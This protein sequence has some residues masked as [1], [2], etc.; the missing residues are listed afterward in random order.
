MN[1]YTH[2]AHV[3][4]EMYCH[5]FDYRKEFDFYHSILSEFS[6]VSI[7]EHGCGSGHLAKHFI[8]HGYDYLGVD[9]HDQM[10][11]IARR[12]IPEHHLAQGDMCTFTSQIQKD[13]ILIT[14]RSISYLYDD[15]QIRAML[16]KS[17]HNL[18]S[19]GKLI[20]DAIDGIELFKDFDSSEKEVVVGAYKRISRSIARTPDTYTWDWYAT[21]YQMDDRGDQK[22]GDDHAT[23]RAFTNE[24]I[25]KF[26]SDAGFGQIL[27]Y[28]KETYTW[29]DNY[30]VA[31]KL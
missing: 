19:G 3:Y 24:E 26:L 29:K 27:I 23:V 22:L 30:F 12:S 11:D 7:I 18:K 17:H 6:G 25:T 9:L 10:L 21:Y 1:L 15:G 31:T 5:L 20:F 2:L 16:A 8:Q 14:G 28:P 4:H 13:A